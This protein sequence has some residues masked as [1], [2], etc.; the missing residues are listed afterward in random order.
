MRF[1]CYLI[2]SYII[3]IKYDLL[4]ILGI[5]KT[6]TSHERYS[7][8]SDI[9]LYDVLLISSAFQDMTLFHMTLESFPLLCKG[10]E[11]SET[12]DYEVAK[13]LKY[14]CFKPSRYQIIY[15]HS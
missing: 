7:V 14:A 10:V 3:N 1:N 15:L 13:T 8:I 12:Q 4:N 2:H 5:T 11:Y 9:F 6:S